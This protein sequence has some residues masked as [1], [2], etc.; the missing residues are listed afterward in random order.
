MAFFS[1]AFLAAASF[2]ARLAAAFLAALNGV[3]GVPVG[4]MTR[5]FL[6]TNPLRVTLNS[7]VGIL[8]IALPSALGCVMVGAYLVNLV[9]V[10]AITWIT[11]MVAAVNYR[12]QEYN[13]DHDD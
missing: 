13:S 4:G 6:P 12:Y 8:A 11:V 5:P 10:R 2:L 7:P 1:A 3:S 9:S